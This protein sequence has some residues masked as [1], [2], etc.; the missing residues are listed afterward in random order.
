MLALFLGIKSDIA[1]NKNNKD[2]VAI[3][4]LLALNIGIADMGI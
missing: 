1:I 4:P 2:K 3:T